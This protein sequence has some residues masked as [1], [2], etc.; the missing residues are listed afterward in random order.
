MAV[1]VALASP[2]R[3]R[4]AY[5]SRRAPAQAPPELRPQWHL[6]KAEEG[7]GRL[8]IYKSLEKF[9]LSKMSYSVDLFYGAV[10][11]PTKIIVSVGDI[12]LTIQSEKETFH[13]IKPDKE[14]VPDGYSPVDEYLLRLCWGIKTDGMSIYVG[15]GEYGHYTLKLT[16]KD[17]NIFEYEISRLAASSL[18][19]AFERMMSRMLADNQHEA[20]TTCMIEFCNS[21]MQWQAQVITRTQFMHQPHANQR[22]R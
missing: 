16:L 18:A 17:L 4:L 9:L 7:Y 21:N 8:L 2:R 20:P 14:V 15:V 1:D 5:P 13:F 22:R 10:D 3:L 12:Q 19:A 11:W 6:T